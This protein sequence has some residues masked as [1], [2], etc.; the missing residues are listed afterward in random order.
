MDF[1]AIL[2]LLQLSISLLNSCLFLPKPV[3]NTLISKDFIFLSVVKQSRSIFRWRGMVSSRRRRCSSQGEFWF[4]PSW[5][6]TQSQEDTHI[7]CNGS[8]PPPGSRQWGHPSHGKEKSI[9]APH[10][11]P[12]YD[13]W[14]T[15]SAKA[16]A[17]PW[18]RG[19]IKTIS[20]IPH[21]V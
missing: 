7:I 14:Q 12:I 5:L 2:Q 6:L 13:E 9:I 4:G 11:S 20:I 21:S 17:L 15:Q 18:K 8:K 10:S 19:L 16:I 3:S 1:L